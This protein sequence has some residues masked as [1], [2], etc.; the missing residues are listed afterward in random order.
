MLPPGVKVR[1]DGTV[2]EGAGAVGVAVDSAS[3]IEA[4]TREDDPFDRVEQ[5]GLAE[6]RQRLETP[7]ARCDED[8]DPS[9]SVDTLAY[10][11]VARSR[12][13]RLPAEGGLDLERRL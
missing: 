7:L 2:I 13:R 10:L 4:T 11:P 3:L 1:V 5:I 6:A 8:P 9:L 12:V